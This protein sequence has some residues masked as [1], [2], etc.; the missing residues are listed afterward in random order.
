VRVTQ[1]IER[2]QGNLRVQPER[3]FQCF[4]VDDEGTASR[5]TTYRG[6]GCEK[7]YYHEVPR[8]CMGSIPEG[9]F[10]QAAGPFHQVV[11]QVNPLGLRRRG[12]SMGMGYDIGE[13]WRAPIVAPSGPLPTPANRKPPRIV[14]ESSRSVNGGGNRHGCRWTQAPSDRHSL[15][16]LCLYLGG[17]ALPRSTTRLFFFPAAPKRLAGRF[18][19]PP[20]G[21]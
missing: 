7:T 18:S 2:A 1:T 13:T 16:G 21:G 4:M 9:K 14:V 3:V 19:T 15:A 8:G 5:A 20:I 17:Q 10:P 12:V 11:I 6:M